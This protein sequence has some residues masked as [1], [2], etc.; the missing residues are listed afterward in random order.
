MKAPIREGSPLRALFRPRGIAVIGASPDT[1]KLGYKLVRNIKE[2]GYAGNIIPVNIKGGKVHGLDSCRSIGEAEGRVDIAI[3]CLPSHLVKGT[4]E[5]VGEKGIPF[6]VIISAGFGEIGNVEEEKELVECAERHRVRILGP[7]V[8]G[9]I[10]TPHSLNAQFGPDEIMEGRVAIITQSGALGAAL[11]G[12][13]FEEGIGV[14]GVVSTGNKADI[15]DQELLDFFCSDPNTDAILMYIEGLKDGRRFIE[16]VSRVSRTKPIIVVKS[17]TTEEGARAV[18]SH[19]ASLSGNDRIFDGAFAQSGVIRASTIKDALDWTRTMVDL[20]APEKRNTMIITNGG[21]LGAIAVD[22]STRAGIPLFDDTEWIKGEM[23]AIFPSYAT[24]DNPLDITAQVPY[25]TYLKGLKKVMD[26]DGIG[27]V[28]GIYSP[29]SGSDIPEFTRQMIRII[30]KPKK[31]IMICTFGGRASMDQ[32]QE[33]KRQ[34]I[35]AFYYPEEAVSSLSALYDHYD[36]ANR[37][38]YE[39]GTKVPWNTDEVRSRTERLPA[40]FTGLKDALSIIGTGPFRT[41]QWRAVDDRG[42]LMEAAQE[43]GYPLVMKS[44]GKELVHK[45]EHGGVIECIGREQELMEGFDA[46]RRISSEVILM[47]RVKGPE[48][49]M[50]ALRD[51]VFG[52]V[53]MFGMGGPLVEVLEDIVFRVAPLSS[54]DAYDMLDGIRSKAVLEGVGRRGGAD[55]SELADLLRYLGDLVAEVDQVLEIEINPLF[56][57]DGGPVA[58]D[59]R[60]KLDE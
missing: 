60:I 14:S 24:L 56:L 20:P 25:T 11:M 9:L 47:E 10:Y 42:S 2:G 28:I 36:F 49:I 16:T 46:I 58:A 57:T 6:A 13:A 17:G 19:T 23:G 7:N 5:E 21:G 15:S 43:I 32:I 52:P 59:A 22:G 41:A 27:S 35:P 29:T 4:L 3:I 51:P 34:G 40:G 39:K 26:H 55:K 18:R 1:D 38:H 37:D 45:S 54:R 53:V 50:G 31:P 12:K 44:A 33:L 8:F 30:G 48:L